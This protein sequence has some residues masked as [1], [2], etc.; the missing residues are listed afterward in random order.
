MLM[1]ATLAGCGSPQRANPSLD[2]SL[3]EGRSALRAMQR[4]PKPLERPV[5]VLAGY[6]DPG[7]GVHTTAEMLRAVTSTPEMII[8]VPFWSVRSW[9]SCRDR[10]LDRL[11]Q[12][13]PSPDEARTVE[14]DVVGVSMGGLVA[15]FAAMAR[16]ESDPGRV[17]EINRLFTLATPHRGAR[18]AW[19]A[20]FDNRPFD[21]QAG[22]AFL[23]RLDAELGARAYEVYPYV[24]LCDTIVGVENTAMTGET[25]WWVPNPPFEASHLNMPS[26]ERLIADIARR[27]RGE[28]PFATEPRAALPTRSRTSENPTPARV[29]RRILARSGGSG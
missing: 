5:L 24:R 21:M 16:A 22:S 28:R 9:E 3:E 18:L 1:F 7:G 10:A 2:L 6:W 23:A 11:E 19:I 29:D 26:D 12:R 25:P 8:E 17:L 15:R 27:L 4:T 20:S 13:F 14:V